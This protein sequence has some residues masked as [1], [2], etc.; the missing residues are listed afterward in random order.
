MK[1]PAKQNRSSYDNMQDRLLDG[2]KQILRFAEDSNDLTQV[3]LEDFPRSEHVACLLE[4]MKQFADMLHTGFMTAIYEVSVERPGAKY[5]DRR[6]EA[7]DSGTIQ[8]STVQYVTC[9]T[10]LGLRKIPDPL[11]AVHPSSNRNLDV[12]KAVAL[13]KPIVLL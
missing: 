7:W 10:E 12:E 3:V 9:T 1:S 2:L 11:T 6:M 13:V 4:P 8:S 5:D